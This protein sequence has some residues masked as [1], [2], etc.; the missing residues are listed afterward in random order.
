MVVKPSGKTKMIMRIIMKT[1][2][3]RTKTNNCQFQ[4]ILLLK[5]YQ[6]RNT[7]KTAAA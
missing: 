6:R 7:R 3:K 5:S 1:I 4:L 2:C